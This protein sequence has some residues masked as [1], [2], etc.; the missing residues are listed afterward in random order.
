VYA[1][2]DS[3]GYSQEDIAVLFVAG[4]GSSMFFGTFVGSLADRL[5]RKRFCLLYAILYI[6]SCLTKHV[7]SFH[8]LMLGRL[9]V[10]TSAHRRLIRRLA[11]G[12][13]TIGRID[14]SLKTLVDCVTDSTNAAL[15]TRLLLAGRCRLIDRPIHTLP[16]IFT[17]SG[18]EY[19]HPSIN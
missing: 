6:A 16:H 15:L 19:M 1:L 9:L 12:Q 2:Y 4:F 3:Y 5:G 7:K 13:G 10:S 17:Y 18:N 11:G 14:D 8:V